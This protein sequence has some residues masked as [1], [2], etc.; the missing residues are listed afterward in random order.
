MFPKDF[1]W[2]CASSAYQ[3]EGGVNEGGRGQ[4]IW[5]T[6]SHTPGK[7]YEGQNADVTCD[8]Y[9]CFREDIAIMRQMG[10]QAYRLSL[11]WPRILPNGVGAV[12]DEGIA[13][14]NA[15]I[16][17]LLKNGIE[18]YI[19]LYHWDLP[20]ALYER[21]GWNNSDCVSWFAEYAAV[22]SR[23]FSDRVTNF[24]TFN[25]PQCFTGISHLHGAHAPGVKLEQKALFQ[26][27]HHVLKAHGAAVI[28][29][30]ENAVRPIRVGYAPTCG[31]VY[32]KSET[33]EDIEACRRYLFSCPEDM[34]NWTWNVPWFSDP[35][36]LGKYPEDG[37]KKYAPYLPE[38]TPEDMQLIHQ[39]LDF[40]GENIYNGIQI[41]AGENGEPIYVNRDPGFAITG[42]DWP[43]TPQCLR[44]GLKLLYERYR[45][46][47]LLTEN[48]MCNR[49]V[50]SCDG[51]VHDPQRIDFLNRYILAMKQ[52]MDEGAD[53]RG[54]FQWTLTDN[55]EW[56]QGYR[57]KFGLIYVDFVT[58]R[59]I[60]KDSS[61]WFEE[62][63]RTNG[64]NLQPDR[65]PQYLPALPPDVQPLWHYPEKSAAVVDEPLLLHVDGGYG[66]LNSICLKPGDVLRLPAHYG[67]IDLRGDMTLT[68]Y[69]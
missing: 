17:E 37:L 16:D 47:I 40:M 55:Y 69:R 4:S 52:A 29:L 3:I 28:A 50:V 43:V 34:S 68:A 67:S 7:I 26:M 61:Y 35:V 22:V 66:T 21:G 49:D 51:R 32:P 63:I 53:I 44:W 11:S 30:R 5:D 39:P 38:I 18:P 12:N 6:F 13:F 64:A 20:L 59:R 57:D 8:F 42:N 27:V 46:P 14:Y 25:E 10:V 41:R 58:Q 65:P 33:P 23:A 1:I 15:V 54:Y 60:R 56:D 62:L 31:M 9:H 2:G 19:T 36:F 45:L 48:G 24:I